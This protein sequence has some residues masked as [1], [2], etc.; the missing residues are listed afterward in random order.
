[1]T[2]R[3]RAALVAI[4]LPFACHAGALG[5][6]PSELLVLRVQCKD[7]P[8]CRYRG[9]DLFLTLELSHRHPRPVEIP[10]AFLRQRGPSIK[11]VGQQTR[12]ETQV[13]TL[14]AQADPSE[15]LEP[16]APG[17]VA[18]LEWVL[19]PGDFEQLGPGN[20]SFAAE[21]TIAAEVKADG[22]LIAARASQ[23]LIIRQP[24][25]ERA[26]SLDVS[27]RLPK[28]KVSRGNEL[29]VV[30]TIR[31]GTGREVRLNTLALRAPS[32]SLQVRDAQGNAV[33]LGP[34]PTPAADDGVVG[35]ERL[36]PGEA[37]TLG[38]A[39][40]FGDEPPAGRYS[41]AL[42]CALSPGPAGGDWEGVLESA[43]VKFSIR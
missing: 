13:P 16:L 42:R 20:H 19:K 23:T 2:S 34:P 17:A 15:S 8:G 41:I 3:A 5:S 25:P 40:I 7:N 22:K 6:G 11:L 31:N 33:R 38:Y 28:R 35:R 12:A 39:A 27:L 14:P 10:L 32:L 24:A 43:W 30:A 37:L 1:M 21:V 36:A 29:E 26:R 18:T 4:L 9:E